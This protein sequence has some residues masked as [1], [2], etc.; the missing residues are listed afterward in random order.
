MLGIE[1]VLPQGQICRTRAV[2]RSSTG[3]DLKRLFIG[4][5]GCFGIV[6]EVTLRVFPRPGSRSL[7]GFRFPSFEDGFAAVRGL[8]A[9]GL[10]PS[11]MDYG[12]ATHDPAGASKLYLGFE[13]SPELV[14]AEVCVAGRIC[15]E[16]A[17]AA[18]APA[19]A[20]NFWRERHAAA[21]RFAH[22]RK[23]RRALAADGWHRDWIHVA[24]PAAKVLDFRNCAL[25]II[26]RRGVEFRASGLWTRPELFS[27]AVAKQG[28]DEAR[29]TLEE[30]VFT[31][32]EAVHRYAGSME[33]CH[34]VGAKLAPLMEPEHGLNL[35]LMRSLKAAVD[36]EGIMNPGKLALS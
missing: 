5:E 25:D 9:A 15:R 10:S 12:D 23:A 31:L 36:P 7:L 30:T 20:E 17:C 3:I 32:L 19:E 18:L 14:D 4:G 28:G 16:S 1:A 21:R 34:G 2:A 8:F 26:T 13:G 22:D 24:L 33:Y 29:K 11:L 27:F 6:T 35:E